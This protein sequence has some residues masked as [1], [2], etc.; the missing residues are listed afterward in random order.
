MKIKSLSLIVILFVFLACNNEPR[1]P[2]IYEPNPEFTLMGIGFFGQFYA[3][4]PHYVFSFTFLTDGMLN[5]DS[6]AIVAPGQFLF[7][8]DFFVP[9][10][11]LD[12]LQNVPADFVLT[13]RALL[14]MLAGEYRASG[15]VG[16]RDFGNAFT[17]APG[18]RF[19]VDNTTYIIGARIEYIEEN[20]FFS[21]R[22]LI[23]EGSFTV[24]ADGIEFNF[25]TENGF[26]INGIYRLP[27]EVSERK[28]RVRYSSERELEKF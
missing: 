18:E 8:E 7:I 15:K 12:F 13:E 2:H 28:I 6:T 24:S 10:E 1:P 9:K 17:F 11:R 27:P 19:T 25:V 23:T 14:E 16:A 5:E 26:V 22:K 21:A 20:P 3:H 4:I